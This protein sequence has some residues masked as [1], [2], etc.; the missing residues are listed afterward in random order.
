MTLADDL[1]LEK[2][3]FDPDP[4]AFR[5]DAVLAEKKLPVGTTRRLLVRM[6][7]AC[8]LVGEAPA[9]L[10]DVVSANP[11]QKDTVIPKLTF[12]SRSVEPSF[13]TLIVALAPGEEA[14]RTTWSKDGRILTVTWRAQTDLIHFSDGTDGRTR[15]RIT[16]GDSILFLAN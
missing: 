6:V 1:V 8:N 3:E 12:T 14:P 11:P 9:A 2:S 13:K 5:A 7:S 4:S 16:R 15:F 10:I